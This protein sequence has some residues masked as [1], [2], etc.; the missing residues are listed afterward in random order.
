MAGVSFSMTL[1]PS[2]A[3]A[4]LLGIWHADGRAACTG[5]LRDWQGESIADVLAITG[6]PWTV[7]V[8]ALATAEQC[9]VSNVVIL[10]NDAD[11]VRALSPPFRPPA[12]TQSKRIFYS[13]TEWV[14]VGWGASDGEGVAH[15]QA[16]QQLG[17]RWGG[18]W[19][20]MQ[21]GDLP[22]ARELWQQTNQPKS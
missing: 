12:P 21:V 16:L 7:L 10:T 19:R 20:V 17:G 18:Q 4:I 11:L 9:D 8:Q 22:K 6:E 13:R 15:W 2:T 14:D 5:A 3:D 1:S